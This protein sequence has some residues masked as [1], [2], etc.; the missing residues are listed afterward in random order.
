M[1]G[2]TLVLAAARRPGLLRS[3]WLYEPVIAAPGVLPPESPN[4]MAD[5]ALRRRARFASRDDARA[6]YA[7]K[8]P[9]DRLHPDALRAYVEGGFAEEADGSVVLR[10]VPATEAAVFRGAAGSGAWEALPALALPVAVVTGRHEGAGAVAL[11]PPALA[12]LAHGTLV[13]RRHLGHFG[14]L[15]DPAGTARDIEAWVE[16]NR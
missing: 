10:C 6:N 5:A 4:P 13:E 7:S 8:P 12:Q 15:E 2:A 16:A 3:L 9:L 11:A 1:G 14:P